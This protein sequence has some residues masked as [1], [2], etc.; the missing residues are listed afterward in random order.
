MLI[1]IAMLL[2]CGEPECSEISGR[3]AAC[4]LPHSLPVSYRMEECSSYGQYH[5]AA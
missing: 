1:V 4:R 3:L 5:T 2:F